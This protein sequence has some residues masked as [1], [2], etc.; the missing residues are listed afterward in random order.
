VND[1]RATKS[2]GGEETGGNPVLGGVSLLSLVIPEEC[3]EEG[4]NVLLLLWIELLNILNAGEHFFI[5]FY[6][7]FTD[8]EIY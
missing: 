8:Q 1:N 5:Q 7:R 6:G 3:I 4:E 2:L